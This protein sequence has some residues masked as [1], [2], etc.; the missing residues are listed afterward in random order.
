MWQVVCAQ[1]KVHMLWARDTYNVRFSL[2]YARESLE[3]RCNTPGSRWRAVIAAGIHA[4]IRAVTATLRSLAH[5]ASPPLHCYVYKDRP[6]EH[7]V[8]CS[9][10]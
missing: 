7:Y 4:G 5:A 3:L 10:T 2:G 8:K 6:I 9:A 1:L